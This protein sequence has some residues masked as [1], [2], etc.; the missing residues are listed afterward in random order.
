M[1]KHIYLSL[2]L[3]LGLIAC[4]SPKKNEAV[5]TTSTTVQTTAPVKGVW[6]TNVASDALHSRTKIQETVAICKNSGIT[7]I[8]VV[9]WNRGRTL[10]PSQLM[11]TEYNQPIMEKFAGRDP[12][13]E[14]IEEGH[15][16]GLK[17]HA[18]FEFGFATSYQDPTGG[19]ILRKHPEWKAIDNTGKLVSKNGFQWMNAIN[20]QAQQ[21][22]KSLVMEVVTKYDVDGIQGDDRLPAMPSLGG[23]DA[24]TLD[25]YKKE[26]NGQ[27]PPNDYMDAAWLTWRADKLTAFLGELYNE[28]K[29][30]K[31]NMI[32]SMAPSIHPW[33]KEEYLQDW[34]T[35]LEKG[36]CDYVIPQVYRYT[37]EAYT[38]T[39]KEQVSFLKEDQKSKF[40]AGVL[41]QVDGKNPTQ[42]M[43]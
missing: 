38:N 17:V 24:Y 9:T 30:A 7:D 35:W 18:W 22:V 6:V 13:Q 43:L 26:H 5:P 2:F 3:S 36:Y 29:A 23:Y 21:F 19:E 20:P 12:L 34:P 41:L 37:M 40:F 25:L 15:K 32:V 27:L 42:G 31:P 10:Y 14:M 16:A 39:L 1:K 33:A 4:N 28:V 11:Q 8:Y